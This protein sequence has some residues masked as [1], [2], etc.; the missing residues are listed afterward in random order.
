[1]VADRMGP[2][3]VADRMGPMI[4]ADGQYKST[5]KSNPLVYQKTRL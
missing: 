5:R 4:V 2:T 3:I 1:M